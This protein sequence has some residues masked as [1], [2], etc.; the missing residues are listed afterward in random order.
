MPKAAVELLRKVFKAG[1]PKAVSTEELAKLFAEQR[2]SDIHRAVWLPKL[3]EMAKHREVPPDRLIEEEPLYK[4]YRYQRNPQGLMD[5]GF[6]EHPHGP[7]DY[8]TETALQYEFGYSLDD[9]AKWNKEGLPKDV[10]KQLAGHFKRRATASP[11]GLVEEDLRDPK[12]LY[13]GMNPKE[14]IGIV[15]EHQRTPDSRFIK[16]FADPD[17]VWGI[18]ANTGVEDFIY[19][20]GMGFSEVIQARAKNVLAKLKDQYRIL[21]LSVASPAA[22]LLEP[23]EAEAGVGDIVKKGA[24]KVLTGVR[25]SA[26]ERLVGLEV[27]PGKVIKEVQK[28][29]RPSDRHLVFE[30]GTRQTVSKDYIHTLSR[31]RGTDRYMQKLQENPD[32]ESKIMQALKSLEYHRQRQSPFETRVSKDSWRKQH[33]QKLKELGTPEDQIQPYVWVHSEGFYMPKGYAEVLDKAGFIKIQG[34]GRPSKLPWPEDFKIE[35]GE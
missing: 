19:R 35:I 31:E 12:G 11:E 1:T 13:W 23:D 7:M 26:Q 18:E 15:P 2:G 20:G 24:K 17:A 32:P 25:S 34:K 14:V 8:A 3:R 10:L 33:V 5:K 27:Q 29:R 28:G 16:G 6:V 4:L 22:S 9:I 21:G 30:D